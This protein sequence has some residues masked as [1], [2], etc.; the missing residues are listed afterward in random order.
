[1]VHPELE[2]GGGCPSLHPRCRSGKAANGR[3]RPPVVMEGTT[4]IVKSG[5]RAGSPSNSSG[6]ATASRRP[7]SRRR[8]RWRTRCPP[9]TEHGS[10]PAPP[11]PLPPPPHRGTQFPRDAVAAGSASLGRPAAGGARKPGLVLAG[12]REGR[13]SGT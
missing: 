5:S 13:V 7:T 2:P 1:M 4:W 3:R 9:C 11:G 6:K 10:T 12:A 8:P